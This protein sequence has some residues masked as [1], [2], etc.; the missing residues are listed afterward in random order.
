[1]RY[2]KLFLIVGFIL[3]SLFIAACTVDMPDT[4]IFNDTDNRSDE[5]RTIGQNGQNQNNQDQNGNN[6]NFCSND[7]RNVDVCFELY[8]PVCGWF[9]KNISC[10]N[11]PCNLIFNNECYACKDERVEYWTFGNCSDSM[12]STCPSPQIDYQQALEYLDD[13]SRITQ[14][15]GLCVTIQLRNGTIIHTREP[16]FDDILNQIRQCTMCGDITIVTE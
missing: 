13:A 9:Y 16:K 8:R 15:Q 2:E 4:G 3:M 6:Y 1:M 14:T 11:P 10:L 12:N 7:D 5:N